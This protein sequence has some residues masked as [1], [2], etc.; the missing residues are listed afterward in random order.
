MVFI[1]FAYSLFPFSAYGF[2]FA[3]FYSIK[4]VIFFRLLVECK[5]CFEFAPQKK[6]LKTG[7]LQKGTTRNVYWDCCECAEIDTDHRHLITLYRLG[8]KRKT[9]N[10]NWNK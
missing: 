4:S 9:N 7:R 6:W 8:G 1:D 10:Y 3:I 5:R 2:L